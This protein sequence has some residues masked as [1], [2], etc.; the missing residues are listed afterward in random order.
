[1][2]KENKNDNILN[3]IFKIFWVFF[4][5]CIIGYIMEVSLHLIQT[6]TFQTR[7][8]LIYGPFAPV[9][10][11]GMLAFYL[12][13]PKIKHLYNI[14]FA[15]ALLGGVTEYLCSYFQERFF[16]TISWDY[17]DLFMNI[18]G[19]TSIMYCIL[20]GILGIVF[21]KA[22]HPYL[23]KMFNKI[24]INVVTKA[25]TTF[26]ILFMIFN[27]SISSMAA[28]RQYERRER[29]AA[30]NQIDKFLD[31]YYPDELMNKVFANKIEK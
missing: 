22:I 16:G 23:E 19:R 29:I 27:I 30:E 14:F 11:L 28:K 20:W 4:I 8:G 10:G 17:S 31:K 26:T 12:I 7:Q 5:G 25:I 24:N 13:L 21:I 18:N 15:S 9:Y 6:H 2:D 3:K 1:M